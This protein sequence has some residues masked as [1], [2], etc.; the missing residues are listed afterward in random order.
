M[1]SGILATCSRLGQSFWFV[2]RTLKAFPRRREHV[3]AIL[4]QIYALGN[5]SML[6][7][8]VAGCFIGMVV[9]LQGYMSLEHYGAS[10]EVGG[11]TAYSIYRELGPV[12][13]GLLFAGRVGSLL[14]SEI[15]LMQINQQFVCLEMLS[16]N[17][18]RLVL[19]PRFFAVLVSVPALNILFCLSAV[20]SSYLIC[21]SALGV[22]DGVFWN[23]LEYRSLF[24]RDVMH[25]VTKSFIFG[26]V[27]AWVALYQGMYTEKT[28]LGLAKATTAAVVSSS[29]YILAIDYIFTALSRSFL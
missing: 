29:L 24:F 13:T 5:Q 27:I 4:Q 26:G 12:V 25:G 2:L 8:F 7:V 18:S 20:M 19:F 22:S 21:T 10:S 16:I 15:G 1:S 23:S 17:A 6:I 3:K 9:T 14:A 11:L 28:R